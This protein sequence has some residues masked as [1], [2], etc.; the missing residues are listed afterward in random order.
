MSLSSSPD[1]LCLVTSSPTKREASFGAPRRDAKPLASRS[2]NVPSSDPFAP[3]SKLSPSKS[4]TMTTPKGKDGSPWRIKVTVEAEPGD[5]QDENSMSSPT[6]RRSTR[7][8]SQTTSVPLNDAEGSSPVKRRGRPRK[9]DSTP[10][11]NIQTKSIP[12]NDGSSPA[13]RRGRPRKSDTIPALASQEGAGA[14]SENGAPSPAKRRGRPRKSDVAKESPKPRARTP[15]R[16]TRRSIVRSPDDSQESAAEDASYRP[17]SRRQSRQPEHGDSL[18]PEPVRAEAMYGP[19]SPEIEEDVPQTEKSARPTRKSVRDRRR[20]RNSD[21]FGAL[22]DAQSDVSEDHEATPCA[23]SSQPR[24]DD[25]EMWQSMI[26][27]QNENQGQPSEDTEQS[28]DELDIVRPEDFGDT[29]MLHS[30]EFSM[31][32]LDSLPSMQVARE[33]KQ[34]KIAD[35]RPR[36]RAKPPVLRTDPIPRHRTHVTSR[37]A[38]SSPIP[39]V[40]DSVASVS[41]MPSSPPVRFPVRTPS[42]SQKLKSPSAPPAVE[43][44]HFSPTTADT[45]K[46]LNVVSAGKALQGVLDGNGEESSGRRDSMASSNGSHRAGSNY[47]S[48]IFQASPKDDNISHFGSQLNQSTRSLPR[49]SPT[50]SPTPH[51][52]PRNDAEA[53][54]GSVFD[55]PSLSSVQN[56]SSYHRLPTPEDSQPY[57]LH[58]PPPPVS[59]L[60][61]DH[62]TLEPPEQ[63]TQLISPARSQHSQHSEASSGAHT[64]PSPEEDQQ[65][66]EQGSSELPSNVDSS[67]SQKPG[68]DFDA[69]WQRRREAISRKIAEASPEKVIVISSEASSEDSSTDFSRSQE[70]TVGL[71]DDI[72]EEEASRASDTRAAARRQR[73]ERRKQAAE[74][75]ANS[76]NL[77]TGSHG[78][79]RSSGRTPQ[80]SGHGSSSRHDQAPSSSASRPQRSSNRESSAPRSSQTQGANQTNPSSEANESEDTGLFWRESSAPQQPQRRLEKSRDEGLSAIMDQIHTPQDQTPQA[81]PQKVPVFKAPYNMGGG[82]NSP[83]R[84]SPLRQ[85]IMFSSPSAVN[86]SPYQKNEMTVESSI[87]DESAIEEPYP[88]SS[89]TSDIKQLRKELSV[90]RRSSGAFE[91]RRMS[92][93][94][95]EEDEQIERQIEEEG[96]QRL[97]L[98]HSAP[99]RPRDHSEASFQSVEQSQQSRP[100]ASRLSAQSRPSASRLS[101]QSRSAG[102]S[103]PRNNLFDGP[104]P[105]LAPGPVRPNG[106]DT[107][108]SVDTTHDDGM[109]IDGEEYSQPSV[110]HE[111]SR[112]MSLSMNRSAPRLFDGQSSEV[113]QGQEQ[114]HK[115]SSPI[116]QPELQAAAQ[117]QGG[118]LF[119]RIWSSIVP[120]QQE[121]KPE[122]AAKQPAPV[123]PQPVNHA[124]PAP[125]SIPGE[126]TPLPRP[127][128]LRQHQDLPKLKPFSKTHFLSLHHI[129]S[130]YLSH[131]AEFS[132]SHVSNQRLVSQP[133][134]NDSP[135]PIPGVQ[136]HPPFLPLSVY[137]DITFRNRGYEVKFP[138]ELIVVGALFMTLLRLDD[139][140]AYAARYGQ[141]LKWDEVRKKGE[142]RIGGFEV[143]QRLGLLEVGRIIRRYEALGKPVNTMGGAYV[144]WPG[145]TP[146]PGWVQVPK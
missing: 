11:S 146:G 22:A 16:R 27:H 106:D 71:G 128:R 34:P 99:R 66:E 28:D 78:Q 19:R 125:A 145:A 95:D 60:I 91:N 2:P 141:P 43:Q 4:I 126:P 57:S 68:E 13:K 86:S 44:A 142:G 7:I 59:Q 101:A 18:V 48:T 38:I 75:S 52:S 40:N 67:L 42:G 100:S 36:P 92:Q 54:D 61:T 10:V 124:A 108:R 29:T 98:A 49:E 123:A 117:Q 105:R 132:L 17:R 55:G 129:W 90:R 85:Q 69:Y 133:V 136:G 77:S 76:S 144:R 96:T 83:A 74:Q 64:P 113:S 88:E 53:S 31:V 119:G 6:S 1:P 89:E 143:V 5:S 56:S 140:A 120:S 102:P 103:R 21:V 3:S 118:G 112:M 8:I 110:S 58:S 72:W 135:M 9:S 93:R 138:E 104:V 80:S 82:I 14:E 30:E 62:S 134:Y 25:A 47:Q 15:A 24:D 111:H 121:T 94:F 46:L 79:E 39:D 12:L 37:N 116:S 20:T 107:L 137:F 122:P 127:T 115:A 84:S 70:A 73:R 23:A 33:P 63:P 81:T 51:Q 139:E 130:R 97:S 65:E 26:S 109:D 87:M 32:S 114:L 131:P 35:P 41:Y 50:K 45:P